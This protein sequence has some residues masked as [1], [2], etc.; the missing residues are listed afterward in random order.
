MVAGRFF[1]DV[2]S[3]IIDS[4]IFTH[5]TTNVK[6]RKNRLSLVTISKNVRLMGGHK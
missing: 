4:R 6:N 5:V 2:Y 3:S 1:V